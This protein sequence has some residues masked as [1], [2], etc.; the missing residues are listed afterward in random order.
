M[1]EMNRMNAHLDLNVIKRGW[2]MEMDK[3]KGESDECEWYG[4][5]ARRTIER[6]RRWV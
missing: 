1:D 6:T 3:E 2:I 5:I 4:G